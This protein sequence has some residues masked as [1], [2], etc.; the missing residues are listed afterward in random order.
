[1]AWTIAIAAPVGPH[2]AARALEASAFRAGHIFSY[3]LS[4]MPHWKRFRKKLARRGVIC[5][6]KD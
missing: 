4:R 1:M 2:G 3:A 5:A 6:D